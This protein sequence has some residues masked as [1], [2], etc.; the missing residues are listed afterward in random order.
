MIPGHDTEILFGFLWVAE[1]TSV[2]III[3]DVHL[4]VV[5]VGSPWLLLP[6]ATGFSI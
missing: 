5:T 4:M 2:H 3:T 1:T 6:L